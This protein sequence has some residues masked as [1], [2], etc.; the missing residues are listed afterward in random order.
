MIEPKGAEPTHAA[1][2]RHQRRRWTTAAPDVMTADELAL[3]LHCSTITVYRHAEHGDFPARKLGS[4]K[5]GSWRFLKRAIDRWLS[6]RCTCLAK[7][8]E[9]GVET[10]TGNGQG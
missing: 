3:Y 5:T 2:K 10:A 8:G 7:E 4:G 1:P 6:G 9:A